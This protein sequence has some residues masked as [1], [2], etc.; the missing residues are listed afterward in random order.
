MAM[1]KIARTTAA[2]TL[3][4]FVGL[5]MPVAI[6]PDGAKLELRRAPPR[7]YGKQINRIS[8]GIGAA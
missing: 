1:T 3:L 8:C 6:E 7:R 4:N 2:V 5:A